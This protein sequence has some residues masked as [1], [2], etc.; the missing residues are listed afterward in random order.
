MIPS[1][2]R[3]TLTYS[4][5]V[6]VFQAPVQIHTTLA[7]GWVDLHLGTLLDGN[8]PTKYFD[9]PLRSNVLLIGW[10][11]IFPG[12]NGTRFYVG[13]YLTGSPLHCRDRMC[14][15]LWHFEMRFRGSWETYPFSCQP[16]MWFINW[17]ES[18]PWMQ[19]RNAHIVP[20]QVWKF[21]QPGMMTVERNSRVDETF[22]K[23]KDES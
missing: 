4:G 12:C 22:R 9:Y 21:D 13:R 2:T 10:T 18:F 7:L 3:G 16:S 8:L 17:I 15:I 14:I 11:G 1:C 20:G 23:N 6:P 5:Y 19:R